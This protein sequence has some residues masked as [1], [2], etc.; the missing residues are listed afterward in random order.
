MVE[1]DETSVVYRTKDDPVAGGPG[2]SHD[3]KLRV[4][5]VAIECKEDG[6]PGGIRLSVIH[7]FSAKS[8]KGFV[9]DWPHR[10]RPIEVRP[11]K[12]KG[13]PSASC[14]VNSPSIRSEP[15]LFTVIFAKFSSTV[16]D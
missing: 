5:G 11:A 4:A 12:S 6:R 2:R 14:I 13:F 15:F 8:Q 1:V 10:Q 7:D 3:G 16:S 9:A